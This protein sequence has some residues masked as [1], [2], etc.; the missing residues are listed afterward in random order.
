MFLAVLVAMGLAVDKPAAASTPTVAT[1]K[2]GDSAEVRAKLDGQKLSFTD[3]KGQRVAVPPSGVAMAPSVDPPGLKITGMT[4]ITRVAVAQGDIM[5]DV[6]AGTSAV[7]KEDLVDGRP[8]V[9]LSTGE[10]SKVSGIIS[11]VAGG[12]KL[13]MAYELGSTVVATGD[14]VGGWDVEV[15]EGELVLIA[16]DGSK[17]ILNTEGAGANDR[18]SIKSDGAGGVLITVIAGTV[19]VVA[20]N[21]D[22]STLIA[23][24]SVT[25]PTTV[26]GPG[27][28]GVFTS[29]PATP[30][31][32]GGG[33]FVVK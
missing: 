10:G 13:G 16:G 31:N 26:V 32:K 6:P 27:M 19:T 29:Q 11:F 20:E 21:G 30:A 33:S 9:T 22:Q 7:V 1:L 4:G 2:V 5:I 25:V 14:P 8:R 24:Q 23:G 18:V 17:I 28:R 15:T 12:R 3:R